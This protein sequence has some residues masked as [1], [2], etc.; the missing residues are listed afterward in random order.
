MEQGGA[1]QD[2]MEQCGI[3][4]NSMEQHEVRERSSTQRDFQLY[5]GSDSYYNYIITDT[6]DYLCTRPCCTLYV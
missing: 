3:V 2:S 1:M 6:D 4:W 5:D